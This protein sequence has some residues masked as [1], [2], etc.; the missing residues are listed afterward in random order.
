[1][2]LPS[3]WMSITVS[4]FRDHAYI[5]IKDDLPTV[6]AKVLNTI[7]DKVHELLQTGE[8]VIVRVFSDDS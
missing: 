3:V 2:R 5:A 4:F 8:E 1:M 7:D 6:L